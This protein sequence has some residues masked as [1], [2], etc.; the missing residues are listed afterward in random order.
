M[1][2]KVIG[3]LI[4][5]A[6]LLVVI[7]YQN[8]EA[9]MQLLWRKSYR[10]NFREKKSKQSNAVMDRIAFECAETGVSTRKVYTIMIVV[11]LIG[12]LVISFLEESFI[13]GIAAG[14][15]TG[16]VIGRG[17]IRKIYKRKRNSFSIGFFSEAIPIGASALEAT[18]RM[19]VAFEEIATTAI[20]PRVKA[21]FSEL[22]DLW[23]KQNLTPSEAFYRATHR[24]EIPEIIT[25]A[26]VTRTAEQYHAKISRLWM[27]FS[28]EVERERQYAQMKAAKTESGRRNS[29]AFAAISLSG[30]L[31]AY[32]R[33]Q[34]Y[35]TEAT[36]IGFWITVIMITTSTLI[37]RRMGTHIQV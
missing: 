1:I 32:P 4:F 14:C 3:T 27:D 2:A 31:I 37:I 19:E 29:L 5:F 24:W 16:F 34:Q 21:E 33:V 22:A 20:H 36:R 15:V 30:L 11:A 12:S 8:A 23:K 17:Y 25:L 28:A 6:T 13:V 35:M 26:E 18:D 7:H 10:G 9:D